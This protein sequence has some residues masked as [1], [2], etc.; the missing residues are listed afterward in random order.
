[1]ATQSRTASRRG[2][3]SAGRSKSTARRSH[4]LDRPVKTRGRRAA[5]AGT[6][7]A[8]EGLE[9]LL[10]LLGEVGRDEVAV[11]VAD[12]V[13]VIANVLDRQALGVGVALGDAGEDPGHVAAAAAVDLAGDRAVLVGQ[14]G[15]H[16]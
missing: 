14:P 2:S 10:E 8:A 4:P 16:G 6:T 5:P 12:L 9:R 13:E 11:L 7:S 1:A 15:D 3:S